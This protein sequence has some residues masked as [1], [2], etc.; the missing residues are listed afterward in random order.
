M[1]IIKKVKV[2]S[3]SRSTYG[4]EVWCSVYLQ[5]KDRFFKLHQLIQTEQKLTDK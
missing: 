1:I 3:Y 5:Y 2:R 4:P